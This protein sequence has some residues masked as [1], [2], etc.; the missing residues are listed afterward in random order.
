MDRTFHNAA[1]DETYTDSGLFLFPFDRVGLSYLKQSVPA[2]SRSVTLK[3]DDVPYCGWPLYFPVIYFTHI[4]YVT[5]FFLSVSL[6]VHLFI[7]V[8]LSSVF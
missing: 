4:E 3:C 8:C 2:L 1:G 6:S 5:C 7:S